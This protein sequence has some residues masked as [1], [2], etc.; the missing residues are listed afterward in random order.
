M[1]FP[2]EKPSDFG[3][4]PH[5]YGKP[6]GLADWHLLPTTSGFTTSAIASCGAKMD[7]HAIKRISKQQDLSFEHIKLPKH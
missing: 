5:D 2:I 1:E 4:T 7:Y 6:H 3:V